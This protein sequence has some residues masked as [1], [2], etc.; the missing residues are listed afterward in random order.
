MTVSYDPTLPTDRDWVRFLIGDRTADQDTA[1][2]S[3]EEID[4]VLREEPNKYFAA[5][6]CGDQIIAQGQGAVSKSVDDLSIEYGD[7]AESA[8]RAYLQGLREEGA[9]VLYGTSGPT[10]FRTL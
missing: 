10:V 1:K 6:R 7:D 8:Y 2:L 4:A 9:R 5:A 3:D